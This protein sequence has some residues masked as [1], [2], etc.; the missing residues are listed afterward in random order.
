MLSGLMPS[1]VCMESLSQP[2]PNTCSDTGTLVVPP[3]SATSTTPLYVP[4]L[5]P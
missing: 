2:K 4:A 3:G 1:E 5:V